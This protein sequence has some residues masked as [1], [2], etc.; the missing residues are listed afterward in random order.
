MLVNAPQGV[1]VL[2]G[3]CCLQDFLRLNFAIE[4]V[5]GT[6]EEARELLVSEIRRWSEV[7][8]RAGIERQ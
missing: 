1:L 4:P 8:T 6:P 2:V 5:G 7:I 3:T